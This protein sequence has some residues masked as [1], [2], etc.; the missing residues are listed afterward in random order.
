MTLQHLS[1]VG[2]FF[3]EFNT[4]IMLLLLLVSNLSYLWSVL[5]TLG[6]N[7]R[8][9]KHV[10]SSFAR[11][12]TICIF[13]GFLQLLCVVSSTSDGIAGG[14]CTKDQSIPY[15]F[16]VM[17]GLQTIAMFVYICEKLF[18]F[19]SRAKDEDKEDEA[20]PEEDKKKKKKKGNK[21]KDKKEKEKIVL[22]KDQVTGEKLFR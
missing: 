12:R 18:G 5:F 11:V 9:T 3:Y 8:S 4:R 21:K 14:A 6:M 13:S 16:D 19:G 2:I 10:L 20:A 15:L 7:K 17:Y 1:S 22:K